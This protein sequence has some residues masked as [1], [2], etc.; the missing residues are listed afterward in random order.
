MMDQPPPE[1][2]VRPAADVPDDWHIAVRMLPDGSVVIRC[3]I[4][5]LAVPLDWRHRAPEVS[6][7]AP[8][9]PRCLAI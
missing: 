3:R 7:D 6:I 2:Y 8:M 4:V 1:P 9:C 5:P